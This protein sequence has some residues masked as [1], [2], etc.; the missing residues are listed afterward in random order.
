M[1]GALGRA[2]RRVP[3]GASRGSP[4]SVLREPAAPGDQPRLL[5][6]GILL[7]QAREPREPLLQSP[8]FTSHKRRRPACRGR[9]A[10]YAID[11]PVS[12]ADGA[13][14]KA[15]M[16][17]RL[18]FIA[19]LSPCSSLPRSPPYHP[20]HP[21]EGLIRGRGHNKKWNHTLHINQG[22]IFLKGSTLHV[23]S[24][25]GEAAL[26]AQSI[27]ECRFS[28]PGQCHV[29]FPIT[30]PTKSPPQPCPATPLPHLRHTRAPVITVIPGARHWNASLLPGSQHIPWAAPTRARGS[31]AT[32]SPPQ[33]GVAWH[34]ESP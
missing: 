34:G 16:N 22:S 29:P 18:G 11:C 33:G 19:L 24:W 4:G 17:H 8:S 7:A 9:Y 20:S 10:H 13:C 23:P 25:S 2:G 32:G 1:Q 6:L 27:P 5:G 14:D 15:E 26:P 31:C 28:I 3:A 21:S 30:H 12:P